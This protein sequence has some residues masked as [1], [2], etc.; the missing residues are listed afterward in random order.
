MPTDYTA[1]VIS[2]LAPKNIFADHS[3]VHSSDIDQAQAGLTDAFLPVE[4][5]VR[6]IPSAIDARLNV[7]KIGRITA[8]YLRFGDAVRI[9]T[10]E[11]AN[12]HVDIPVSGTMV[13]RTGLRDPVYSNPQTA[14]VFMPFLPAD[15]DCD[16]EC[17]QLCLMLPRMDLRVELENLLGRPITSPLDF[18]TT[19]DLTNSQGAAFIHLL[20]LMDLESRHPDGLLSHRLAVQRLEQMLIDVLIFNQPHNYSD[21]IRSRQPAAGV[22][23]ISRA[24]DLLRSNPGHPWTAGELAAAISVSTRSLHDGFRRSMGTSPMAYLRQ[25]RLHAVHDELASA[26]P[27]SVTVTEAAARWG[28]VHLGRFAATYQRQFAELPSDTL[29]SGPIVPRKNRAAMSA[30]SEGTPRP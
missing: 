30:P 9:R 7:I 14:A 17:A 10:A 2:T 25:L 24:V 12:Y 26:E 21:A 15:I 19:L 22:R 6:Q 1:R 28:F 29:K 4:L 13:A 16:S 8:G 23:P 20:R 3:V 11:A 18:A 5:T 27:G